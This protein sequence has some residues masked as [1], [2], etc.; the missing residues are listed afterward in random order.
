MSSRFHRGDSTD[1]HI[2]SHHY[3]I[4]AFSHCPCL[5]TIKFDYYF[6]SHTKCL[7]GGFQFCWPRYFLPYDLYWQ[8]CSRRG[9]GSL[10]IQ[11]FR[12]ASLFLCWS[13]GKCGRGHPLLWWTENTWNEWVLLS[14]AQMHKRTAWRQT[15][16]DIL[17]ADLTSSR[18]NSWLYIACIK[19]CKVRSVNC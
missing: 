14:S 3:Q 18:V 2:F 13:H 9:L 19:K 5:F 16:N 6:L 1:P 12:L 8:T 11:R 4:Q 15:H 10:L 17:N 7:M